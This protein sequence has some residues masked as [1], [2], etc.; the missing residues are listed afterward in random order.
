MSNERRTADDVTDPIVSNAYREMSTERTPEHLDH[1]VLNEARD[2]AKQ[3]HRSAMAWLRPAAWVA[4]VGLCLAIVLEVAD[5]PL[6]E[7]DVFSDAIKAEKEVLDEPGA[8]DVPASAPV[9]ARAVETSPVENSAVS[10]RPGLLQA[11]PARAEAGR[12]DAGSADGVVGPVEALERKSSP[13]DAPAAIE[14]DLDADRQ[15][16]RD[17]EDRARL[18]AGSDEFEEELVIQNLTSPGVASDVAADHYS[19]VERFCNEAQTADPNAWLECILELENRS[20]PEAAMHEREL[21]REAY[22]VFYAAPENRD[23]DR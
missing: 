7:Q 23:P 19:D 21:L 8:K 20:M 2:A 14:V 13:S 17:A 6:Q 5:L 4:T 18:Q 9:E 15:F 10:E 12:S 11:E 3:R 16:L 22:P 1:A